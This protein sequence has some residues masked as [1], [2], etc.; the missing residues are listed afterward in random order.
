MRKLSY[1]FALLVSFIAFNACTSDVDNY[2]DESAPER[3]SQRID[4]VKKILYSAPNGW[5]MEYY[6]GGT[7]GGYNVFCQFKGDSV[8]MASEKAGDNHDA[9][10]DANGNLITELSSTHF[11]VDQSMG[12]ILSFDTYNKVF[13][14]FAEPKN[15]DYGSAGTGFGGDFEFRV[16]RAVSDTIILQGRKHGMTVRMYPMETSDWAQYLKDVASTQQYMAASSYTLYAGEDTLANVQQ[17]GSYHS[18]I[19]SYVDTLGKQNNVSYPY[20]IT[21]KGYKFYTPVVISKLDPKTNKVKS[22]TI[23]NFSKDFN[24][25]TDERFFPEGDTRYRLETVVPPVVDAFKS[26]QW[27]FAYSKVGAYAEEAWNNFKEGIQKSVS[28]GS[29]VTL[30]WAFIGTYQDKFGFHAQCG[31]DY[32]YVELT[33]RDPNEAGDEIALQYNRNSPTNK[34]AQVYMKSY[35]LTPVLRTFSALNN[36]FR[37]KLETDNPRKP[38]YMKLVDVSDPTHV[39]DLSATSVNYPFKN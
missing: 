13:H 16:L 28:D 37:L 14:Y 7:Y 23:R 3:A 19:F 35:K 31:N 15:D 26:G 30:Y 1:L 20:I 25:A 24:D 21:P 9:G 38:S 36:K 17:Y 12:V 4:E 22:D 34:A 27:F 8:L 2:F 18:M 33:V 32:I 39:V 5:R 11:S 29:E 6:G 10:L